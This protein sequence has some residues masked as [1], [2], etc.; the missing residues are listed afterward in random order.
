[1]AITA[2]SAKVSSSLI[3]AGVKGRTSVRRAFSAP[4]SFP[5]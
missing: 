2:W 1:M 5:C 4:M 3:W